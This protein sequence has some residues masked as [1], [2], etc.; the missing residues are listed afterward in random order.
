M[1]TKKS[2]TKK[3]NTN[4]STAK[5]DVKDNNEAV[6]KTDNNE[7][8]VVN[9]KPQEVL[10]KPDLTRM[11]CVKNISK[12]GLV[13][14]SKRQIGYTIIWDEKEKGST[15]NIELGE[16]VNLKNSDTRFVTEPW[17]RIIEEDE[18]EILKYLNILQNYKE[19][20][21]INNVSDIL[22]LDFDKFKKKFDKLP[23]GYK[24][25]VAEQAADMINSGELDSIKI[26]KYIEDEL[27]IDLSLLVTSKKRTEN[28]NIDIT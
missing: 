1:A 11:I 14:K 19:I 7:S 25:T 26:K 27:N 12:G 4:K 28:N 5:K 10:W 23:K 16:L 9:E 13:Y 8:E 2:D 18:I 21:G 20:L 6:L 3:I 24:N 15:N 17:I 22:R